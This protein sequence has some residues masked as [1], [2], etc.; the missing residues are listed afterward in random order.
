MHGIEVEM[1]GVMWMLGNATTFKYIEERWLVFKEEIDNVRIL[2]EANG[3]NPFG[4]M[5]FIYSMWPILVINNNLP[6]WTSM[7]REH[8][9]MFQVFSQNNVFK[10]LLKR[11]F[12]STYYLN[13]SLIVCYTLIY[14]MFKVIKMC[15]FK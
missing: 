6:P 2:L 4:E 12:S 8:T 7:N 9:R 1:D 15:I 3:V 13:C 14:Y 10:Y 5:R 11:M